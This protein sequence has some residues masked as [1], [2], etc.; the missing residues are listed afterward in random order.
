MDAAQ[1]NAAVAATQQQ[2]AVVAERTALAQATSYAIEADRQRLE[3]T[4]PA[5]EMRATDYASTATAWQ[6]TTE[7]NAYIV[8][9]E[10]NQQAALLEIDRAKRQAEV[11]MMLRNMALFLLILAG[12]IVIGV[13]T[14]L[15]VSLILAGYRRSQWRYSGTPLAALPAR[16]DIL[17]VVGTPNAEVVEL[18]QNSIAVSSDD[19]SK[20]IPRFSRV[21]MSGEKWSR[22]VRH[23]K[24]FG[25]VTTTP[26]EHTILSDD[27]TLRTLLEAMQR[28]EMGVR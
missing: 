7:A 21:G 12:Y 18:L 8:N 3:V 16:N 5:Q 27:W 22:A 6:G 26:G 25:C 1:Y 24:R 11:S 14:M 23:L 9:L 20:I 17:D 28:G 19:D 13:I 10:A 4:Q 2:A 15:S